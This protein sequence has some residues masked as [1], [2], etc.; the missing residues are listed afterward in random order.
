MGLCSYDH[1]FCAYQDTAFNV[2]FVNIAEP[3]SA[4]QTLSNDKCANFIAL[5]EKD[6]VVGDNKDRT[7]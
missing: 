5:I 1:V 7:W 2:A 3:A 6:S 4:T